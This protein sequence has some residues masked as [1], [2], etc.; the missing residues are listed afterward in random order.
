MLKRF[1]ILLLI[2]GLVLCYFG[3][4]GIKDNSKPVKDINTVKSGE[5]R[6]DVIIG[7]KLAEH[8]IIGCY[9]ESYTTRYGIKLPG[10]STYH[11]A[12]GLD[13]WTVVSMSCTALQKKKIEKQLKEYTAKRKGMVTKIP[14]KGKVHKLDRDVEKLLSQLLWEA[15]SN[16]EFEGH[17]SYYEIMYGV[18][19]MKTSKGLLIGGVI[20]LLLLLLIIVVLFVKM[21]K[22]I[23]HSVRYGEDSGADSSY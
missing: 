2:A 3:M 13:D 15:E 19:S 7:G 11:Y 4:E 18:R 10:F 20:C 5:I 9:A 16:G 1:M 17:V 8:N 6:E 14:F 23:I 21:I 22:R 12:I